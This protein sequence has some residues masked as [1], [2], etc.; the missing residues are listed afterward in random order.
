MTL[1]VL[2]ADDEAVARRRIRRYLE[3]DPSVVVVGESADGA[4]AVDAIRS[5][6]P[7]IV[8][9]D[10]QMPGLDGFAV[11]HT[12]AAEALPAV[13]FVTAFDRYALQAFDQHAVDYLLKPFTRDRFE[14]ALSRAKARLERHERD[15]GL[16]ALLRDVR[17]APRHPARVAVPSGERLVVVDWA[18]VDWIGAAD[19]YVTLH[20]GATELLLRE[21]LTRLEQELDPRQFVRIHRSA[22]V[23]IDRIAE[24]YPETHG[25][26]TV[27]LRDGTRLAMSR[28]F[29]DR[30]ERAIRWTR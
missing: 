7:D 14:L 18:D 3:P 12:L 15:Q 1:R 9:L 20:V 5:L 10:V 17:S 21:T 26:F 2:V 23:R 8:F 22:V 11:L 19:N 4:A 27:R 30:V 25:D 16:T 28:T 24:L 6:A 13:I 29:R